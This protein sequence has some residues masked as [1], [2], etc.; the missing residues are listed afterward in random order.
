MTEAQT[1]LPGYLDSLVQRRPSLWSLTSCGVTRSGR[2]IPALLDHD[3]Y[4][5]ASRRARILLVSGLSGRDKD[6]EQGLAALDMFASSGQRFAAEISLSA[7]PCGNPDG[8]ALT[9]NNGVGGDPSTGYPPPDNFFYDPI[10]PESRYLWRWICFQAPDLVLE[11]VNGDRVAWEANEAASRLAPAVGARQMPGGG[12]LLAALGAGSPGGLGPIPGLRLEAPAER[13][14][15][16]LGR[17]WSFIP[18]F[19]SWGPSAARLTLDSRRARSRIN[20]ASVLDSVYGHDLDPINYTQGVGIS[21][22]L[23]LARLAPGNPAVAAEIVEMVTRLGVV[24]PDPF[25]PQPSGANLAG[26]LWDPE[27]AQ[28]TGDGRWSDL[29]LQAAG[30]YQVAPPGVAPPPSDPDFRTEDMFMNGAV[31]GRAYQLSGEGRYLDML[32]QFLL[33]GSI[34]QENG[35]FWHCR[36]APY[37]WGRGNGF[38]AMGLAETLT[39][40]PEDDPRRGRILDMLLAL[41]EGMQSRQNPSGMFPQVLDV[42]GSFQEF[43]ATCMFGYAVARGIR[44]GWLDSSFAAPLQL[45]W[46]GVAERIDDAGNVVDGCIS[47]G[48][49]ESLRDYLDRPAVFG[50]DDRSG[51]LALWF[52]VEMER[53][54]GDSKPA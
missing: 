8:L 28:A 15:A 51:S 53:L 39:Y 10:N 24:P 23:R 13:L 14:G 2:E 18:Q 7:V 50:F 37:F 54:A 32:A 5:P 44:L 20:I 3:A 45:A 47:T 17:L 42:P 30:R 52:A 48:V 27:L 35:L 25:G 26:V 6:V 41:L 38:A 9:R 34:Q 22:R 31:L 43:T 40:L 29:L 1:G 36:S 21:G 4:L 33:D 12:S 46:Q 19:G 16:E 11:L 49:Q